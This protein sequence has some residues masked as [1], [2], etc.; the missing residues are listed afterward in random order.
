MN[1]DQREIRRKLRI[2][3]HAEQCG[4][5][6]KT[7]RYFGIGRSS[8]YRWREA[9]RNDG[10][11]GLTN[12]SPV[13]KSHPNQTPKEVVEK[14]RMEDGQVRA[15]DSI[16]PSANKSNIFPTQMLAGDF[17]ATSEQIPGSFDIVQTVSSDDATKRFGKLKTVRLY[18]RMVRNSQLD[19]LY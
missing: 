8:F 16:L 15:S 19:E 6:G 4:N 5:I 11:A 2:L 18:V 3:V 9:Y 17:K 1:T 13:P 12:S 14:V 10:E 7:C